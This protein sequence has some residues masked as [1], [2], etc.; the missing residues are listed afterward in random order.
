MNTSHT[1]EPLSTRTSITP[2]VPIQHVTFALD[3][4]RNGFEQMPDAP[5]LSTDVVESLPEWACVQTLGSPD[6]LGWFRKRGFQGKFGADLCVDVVGSAD[7]VFRTMVY[8]MPAGTYYGPA[9]EAFYPVLDQMEK[10][11]LHYFTFSNADTLQLFWL[12]AKQW[13]EE[14]AQPVRIRAT[15]EGMLH[16]LQVRRPLDGEMTTRELDAQ[17]KAQ[18][19]I[20]RAQEREARRAAKAERT[21][22]GGAPPKPYHGLQLGQEVT[23]APEDYTTINSLRV[24]VYGYAK[25]NGIR[26]S[27]RLQPDDSVLITRLE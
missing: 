1:T 19:R 10:G 7:S 2:K 22:P 9:R 23:I 13:T 14:R 15:Y 25:R 16:T 27:V 4:R 12:M 5:Q 17:E 24:V 11:L 18:A 20:V 8:K 6:T 3:P 26:L 21:A